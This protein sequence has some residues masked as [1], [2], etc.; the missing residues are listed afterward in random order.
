MGRECKEVAVANITGLDGVGGV[1]KL[2]GDAGG[3]PL[4]GLSLTLL[5]LWEREE[6]GK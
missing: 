6:I 3:P 5:T 2:V 4:A 1:G